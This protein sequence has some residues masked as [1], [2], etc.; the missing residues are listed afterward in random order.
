MLAQG[1]QAIECAEPL[2]HSL[3]RWRHAGAVC[4]HVESL[5]HSELQE[6][7]GQGPTVVHLQMEQRPGVCRR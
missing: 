6:D 3:Q 1:P 7:Q 4:V 5:H 2:K